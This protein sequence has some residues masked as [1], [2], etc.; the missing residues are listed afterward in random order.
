MAWGNGLSSTAGSLWLR[1]VVV[2]DEFGSRQQPVEFPDAVGLEIP[3]ES[4]LGETSVLVRQNV[5][6]PA[7]QTT[8]SRVELGFDL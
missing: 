3:G 5:F 7:V 1:V 8:Q 2:A 6:S 4:Q